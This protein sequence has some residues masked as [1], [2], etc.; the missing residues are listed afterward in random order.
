M[1]TKATLIGITAALALTA[2]L[3]ALSGSAL[4]DPKRPGPSPSPVPA[5]HRP[6]VS[7]SQKQPVVINPAYT[8]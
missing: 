8:G 7:P 4:A 6:T 2:G 5:D 3:A 1:K